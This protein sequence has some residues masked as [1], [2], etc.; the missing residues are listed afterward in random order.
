HINPKE[1]QDLVLDSKFT[2][3]P[4]GRNPGTFRLWEALEGG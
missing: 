2:I 4:A 3:C 1:W